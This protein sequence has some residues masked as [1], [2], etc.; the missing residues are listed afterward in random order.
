M[1]T[2][3]SNAPSGNGSGS[4]T[5]ARRKWTWSSRPARWGV[6][7]P[8]LD[9]RLVDVHPRDPAADF[10]R[11]EQGRAARAAADIQDV[12][13]G[14]QSQQP[15]EPPVLLAGHP[16]ALAEVFAVGVAADLRQDLHG[17]VT[18]GCA[19]QVHSP[20]HGFLPTLGTSSYPWG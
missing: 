8:G 13:G 4:R 16:A 12:V 18:V 2:M 10:A 1:Q 3:A 11:Q 14:G 7:Q 5:S 9:A 15:E 20:G 19:I 6:I 17:E